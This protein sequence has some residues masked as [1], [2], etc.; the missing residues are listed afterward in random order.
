MDR[1]LAQPQGT[2]SPQL[3]TGRLPRPGLNGR[4]GV[5]SAWLVAVLVG[6]LSQGCGGGGDAGSPGGQATMRSIGG[7][8]SGLTGTGLVLGLTGQA[9][10]SVARNGAF[11]FAG[12]VP[13]G[14]PFAVSVEAQ[15]TS[16][17]QIC[18]IAN[19]AGSASA[20][21]ATAVTVTCST[22]TSTF[23]V[24]GSVT[25]L[26][27]SGLQLGLAGNPSVLVLHDGPFAF[28]AQLQEGESF[29]VTVEVQPIAPAQVCTVSSG[30]GTASAASATAV[31]VTCSTSTFTVGGAV[32]GYAGT[33]LV[34]RNNGGD[35]LAIDVGG[36]FAFASRVADG[37]G[38]AVTVQTQPRSPA[39]VCAVSGGSG[40]VS[41]A[42]VTGVAVTCVTS[43]FSVGG[44]VSGYAGTGLVLRNN[45]GDPLAVAGSGPFTFT[46]LVPDGGAFAVTVQAQPTSPAQICA[47]SNGSGTVP[48]AGVSTVQVTCVTSTF[49]IGG[50]VS[51]LAGAG[52]VLRN[53]GGDPLA[54][55]G[56]GPFTFASAVPDGGSYGVTIQAQPT[57]PAQVCAVS[58][59]GGI[60]A[61]AAVSSVAVTCVTSQYRL[62]GAVTG[63]V[64][65]G[66]VLRNGH[67]L[68]VVDT[69]GNFGFSENLPEL[70]PY[71]VTVET[72]PTAPAQ[73]CTVSAGS[74]T[75]PA[76]NVSTVQVTCAASTFTVGGTVTG[77]AGTGLG[78]QLNGGNLQTID[79]DGAFTFAAPLAD[80]AAFDVAV[81]RLPAGPA[82]VCS[83]AGGRGTIVG[84]NIGSVQ[85]TCPSSVELS[86]T[87]IGSS[88]IELQ[89]SAYGIIPTSYAV[90]EL[91][92]FAIPPQRIV[93]T[94]AGDVTSYVHAGLGQ[95]TS[96]SYFVRA[97][98]PGRTI[99]SAQRNATALAA[100]TFPTPASGLRATQVGGA[101]T[102]SWDPYAGA[103]TYSVYRTVYPEL[104]GGA[105]GVVHVGN[106][107]GTSIADATGPT[108]G[109]HH[110]FVFANNATFTL[111]SDAARVA[112]TVPTG[113]RPGVER[114][115]LDLTNSHYDR[116]GLQLHWHGA[117]GATAHHV[118][119]STNPA[120][121]TPLEGSA[122]PPFDLGST[123]LPIVELVPGRYKM[124]IP[125]SLFAAGT[126]IWFRIEAVKGAF[127]ADSEEAVSLVTRPPVPAG[128][129]GVR[130]V[131]KS[132]TRIDLTWV[133]SPQ[134]LTYRIYLLPDWTTAV[135][136]ATL[137]GSSGS[138]SFSHLAR[139]PATG[140]V[141]R[142]TAVSN[143]GVE[144]AP[145]DV[146]TVRTF[147]DEPPVPAA[148]V[149]LPG[150][151]SAQ[152]VW[153]ST[154]CGTGF[155]I[156]GEAGLL[157]ADIDPNFLAKE[158]E[159]AG[160]TCVPWT[161]NVSVSPATMA[162]FLLAGG[163]IWP[164]GV[165][166]VT[167]VYPD[168]SES[169]RS[170]PFVVPFF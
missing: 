119:G 14:T 78:L 98:A 47:V 59:G 64:G 36:V 82:Q 146:A 154:Q 63:L 164:V 110:Y 10:I 16:P 162:A 137:A 23:T 58:N 30:S 2:L 53:N 104:V 85:V 123:S 90:Y 62:G 106:T 42:D 66:L 69:S 55:S 131:A 18:S 60:V 21:S 118:Y 76:S 7:T 70:A 79:R 115:W 92:P 43:T 168:G 12:L 151:F 169:G 28:P 128:V 4:P 29:S 68:L 158:L 116:T 134:A 130:A 51:G 102:L 33:G 77:L 48:G 136:P 11:S 74:G 97:S 8:V 132:P 109:T 44:T 152:L 112:V 40:T 3:A 5:S 83:V 26:A 117:P 140:H 9:S 99:S 46:A 161:V 145:S 108:D 56:S 141:Y 103:A 94:V 22:S 6:L 45:G 75:M 25:G 122:S 73:V 37:G 19:G 125:Y 147:F 87:A 35:P 124:E 20:A 38:F 126:T 120:V 49:S 135:G 86:A 149:N 72:Q 54:V 67:D 155:R 84:A 57:S 80:G 41:G 143:L 121:I 27:G 159:A 111:R 101:V 170:L 139:T 39:Q 156:Y 129:T 81:G 144:S 133:P 107:A 142:V 150:T 32:S 1:I 52:L 114:P 148:F 91:V 24:G 167:E 34:L 65:K 105:Q 17:G 61:G 157:L 165:Y 88:Q 71:A 95:S 13:E 127:A 160:A 153:V 93:G 50:T 163:T 100:V 15:P 31:T 113:A 166:T 96:H 138:P 89:W